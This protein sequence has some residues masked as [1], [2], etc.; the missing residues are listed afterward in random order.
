MVCCNALKITS[1]KRSTTHTLEPTLPAWNFLGIRRVREPREGCVHCE[2]LE[3]RF[4]EVK[5]DF[6]MLPTYGN[7]FESLGN[8]NYFAASIE[9]PQE[10]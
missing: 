5:V 6:T 2:S 1:L 9:F 3:F 10:I 4:A 7:Y 8:P